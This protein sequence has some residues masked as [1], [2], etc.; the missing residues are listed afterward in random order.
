LPSMVPFRS[1][2]TVIHR[3]H[4]EAYIM[5]SPKTISISIGVQIHSPPPDHAVEE[6]DYGFRRW[7]HGAIAVLESPERAVKAHSG[8]GAVGGTEVREKTGSG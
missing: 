2:L 6:P 7:V 3:S 8:Q 5:L 1:V 4:H